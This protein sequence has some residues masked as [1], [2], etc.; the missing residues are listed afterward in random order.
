MP[1]LKFIDCVGFW[2]SWD[3]GI[4]QEWQVAEPEELLALFF[5]IV[6]AQHI[7]FNI[8]LCNLISVLFY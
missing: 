8:V 4:L 1:Y 6:L 2:Y 3:T 7:L 5:I